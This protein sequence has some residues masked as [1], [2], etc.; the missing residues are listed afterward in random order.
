[1]SIS[2][3]NC[4]EIGGVWSRQTI[5]RVAISAGCATLAVLK[6]RSGYSE[7]YAI[8]AATYWFAVLLECGVAM[9]SWVLRLATLGGIVIGLS[10][11]AI[12]VGLFLD[13]RCGCLGGAYE[14]EKAV[15]MMLA[16]VAGLL[17]V[18]CLKVATR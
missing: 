9:L 10:A 5:L 14:H 2:T 13:G 3:A 7:N 15:G 16:G 18:A 12:V 1:M 4:I 17:G 11:A 8:S 6:I